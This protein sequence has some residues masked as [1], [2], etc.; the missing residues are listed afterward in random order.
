[1]PQNKHCSIRLRVDAINSVSGPVDVIA[2]FDVVAMAA[3]TLTDATVADVC[4]ASVVTV[5]EL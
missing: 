4:D 2:P 3:A 1:M 5:M